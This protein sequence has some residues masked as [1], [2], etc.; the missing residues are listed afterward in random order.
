M[1]YKRDAGRT[2]DGPGDR[3]VKELMIYPA[4]QKY[5][6]REPFY[7]MFHYLKRRLVEPMNRQCYVVGYSFRDDDI[8]GLFHDALDQNQG[9]QVVLLDP[10]AETVRAVRSG[11]RTLSGTT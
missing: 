1:G 11:Q 5:S 8:L 7:D 2:A 3:S 9:L 4:Q 6:F 10:E